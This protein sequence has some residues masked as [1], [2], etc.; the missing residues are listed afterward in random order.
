MK[1]QF[2]IGVDFGTDSVRSIISK[3]HNGEEVASS[4]F[5]YPRWRDGL[6]CDPARNQFRQHPI[7]YIEALEFTIRECV[8]K[9]GESVRKN[10][11]AISIDTTGSSPVAVDATGASVHRLG[12]DLW[13]RPYP[14]A[15]VAQGARQ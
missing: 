13:R 12:P 14:A 3:A 9:G 6:H 7:D 1:E 4:V 15:N 2:V 11:K 10:C 8:S 5:Y